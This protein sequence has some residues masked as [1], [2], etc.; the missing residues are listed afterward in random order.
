VVLLRTAIVT[1]AL[2]VF[3]VVP[4]GASAAASATPVARTAASAKTAK[5]HQARA[6]RR[7]TACTSS[8]HRRMS[9]R[10]RRACLAN[11]RKLS[12]HKQPAHA[13]APAA[14]NV[15]AATLPATSSQ[16]AAQA[17]TPVPVAS[18]AP[19][20]NGDL[21]PD[22][23]NLAAVNAATLCLVNQIRGQHGLGGLTINAKLQA[24]AQRHTDDMVAQSYFAHVGPAGDD[25]LS[26]MTDAGYINNSTP[27]YSLG[28]NI[29]WGT[30]TLA[31]PA[32]IVNAWVNSP[33]HL[34]NI[35][36]PAYRDTGMAASSAAPP[37]LAQGQPGSVYT[38]DF[39][40]LGN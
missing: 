9:P 3:V 15:S 18:T 39:G 35:L 8:R 32:A 23:T 33:E 36:D 31:T 21:T 19:C 2:A 25:P 4:A 7:F 37:T 34:A 14:T 38:Q 12:R 1:A 27:S 29:A 11:R 26:R 30:L 22:A 40:G 24:S 20:A 28:E 13:K 6:T 5:R 10:A 17:S 16:T